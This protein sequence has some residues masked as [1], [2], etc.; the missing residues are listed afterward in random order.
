MKISSRLQIPKIK[1]YCLIN[2][3][4]YVTSF[5]SIILLW[6]VRLVSSELDFLYNANLTVDVTALFEGWLTQLS[7]LFSS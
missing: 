4:L 2:A 6:L 1:C 3:S 7:I 5:T